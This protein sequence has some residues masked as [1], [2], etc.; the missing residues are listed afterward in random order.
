MDGWSIRERGR[1]RGRDGISLEKCADA[2]SNYHNKDSEPWRHKEMVYLV[3][4]C[5]CARVVSTEKR[6]RCMKEQIV[7]H[8]HTHTHTHTHAHTLQ[9]V[10]VPRLICTEG[11]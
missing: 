11:R 3:P 8:T 10:G 1:T 9:A 5:P 6:K 2:N 7:S 4:P